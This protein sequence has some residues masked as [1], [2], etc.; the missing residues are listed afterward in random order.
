MR[1]G[2]AVPRRERCGVGDFARSLAKALPDTVECRLIHH[3]KHGS[4][5]A[6]RRAA[7]ATD[8]LDVVHVHFEY[9]LFGT[10]KPY[11]N[12]FAAFVGRLRPPVVVTL[13]G[14]LPELAS[15]WGAGRLG[16]SD[17]LRDL[18]YLP[19]FGRWQR[20]MYGRVAHWVVHSRE[21][22]D[23]V[24]A[25]VG[26][27][28]ATYLPMPVP[29]T[30]RTWRNAEGGDL[31]LVSPGF[32]KSHKG[33]DVFVDVVRELTSCSWVVAGGPQDRRD[34]GYLDEL[35]RLIAA[36]GIGDRVQVTGYLSRPEM[37]EIMCRATMAVFP[38][39]DV[40]GSASMAWA[41]GCGLPVVTTDLP[42]FRSLRSRGAGIELLPIDS[43]DSWPAMIKGLGNDRIR[44]L[45]LARRNREVGS[46]NTFD[47]CAAAL[48][49]IFERV[50]FECRDVHG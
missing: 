2:V 36:S 16:A 11:R 39:R 6:W 28:R 33:Y 30:D 1:V 42:E 20:I 47:A 50:T 8:G 31:I 29:T 34:D 41:I 38:F 25:V 12:R 19:F 46:V 14:Q 10:V 40:A 37:E 7:R 17:I 13:H 3:P 22:L 21:L 9:G 23:R 44:L 45:E 48:V 49:E 35:R 26:G 24:T 18:A 5:R 27:G 4:A 15:R 32:V 43:P